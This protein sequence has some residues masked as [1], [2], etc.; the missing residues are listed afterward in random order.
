LTAAVKV[1]SQH[2]TSSTRHKLV[3]TTPVKVREPASEMDRATGEG[4]RA[5]MLILL[6]SDHREVGSRAIVGACCLVSL[7]ILTQADDVDDLLR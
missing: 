5:E 2:S 1:S 3:E 7:G 4:W 6:R